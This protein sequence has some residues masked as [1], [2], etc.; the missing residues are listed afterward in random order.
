MQNYYSNQQAV[1]SAVFPVVMRKVYTW[2]TLG[3][4]ITALAAILT[5]QSGLLNAIGSGV[6]L[7]FLGELG[8]VIALS[9]G[10]NRMSFTT[11]TLLFV[12]FSVING[13]TLSSIFYVYSIASISTTFFITAGTFGAMSIVGYVT[14]KDLSSMGRIMFMALLGLIIA[15]VVNIFMG[16]TM[17]EWFITYIGVAIFCGLTVYD[18]QKIKRYSLMMIDNPQS[19]AV[20]KVA[21]LGALTLY[22]DFINL[23]LYILRIFGS[24]D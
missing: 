13:I 4:A 11:A 24:R 7:L 6:W 15:T 21:V 12:A 18:T 19:P 20:Q 9:A 17:L 3:L 16:S 14:K 5:A 10:I 23:F 1:Q 8:I 2:M 22:L